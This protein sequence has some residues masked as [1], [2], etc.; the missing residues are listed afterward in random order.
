MRET[1]AHLNA[2]DSTPDSSPPPALSA[3]TRVVLAVLLVLAV[4]GA[5]YLGLDL[6]G[7]AP[8]FYQP[9]RTPLVAAQH[10]LAE[11]YSHA[12]ALLEQMQMVHRELDTA[13]VALANAERLDPADH[14]TI[15]RLRHSLKALE[16]PN[17]VARMNADEL[18][19]TYRELSS[20]IETL[21]HKLE[22]RTDSA[23]GIDGKTGGNGD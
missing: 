14:Q 1:E 8:N 23:V 12:A 22:N 10:H 5:V 15:I 17:T 20:S 7:Q 6:R 18:H 3:R 9:A 13:I 2:I 16:D 4:G 11:S 19:Q 21:I